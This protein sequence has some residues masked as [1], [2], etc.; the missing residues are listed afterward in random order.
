VTECINIALFDQYSLKLVKAEMGRTKLPMFDQYREEHLIL[1]QL[2]KQITTMVRSWNE[3]PLK[4]A[5]E[6]NERINEE[7]IGTILVST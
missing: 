3:L 1:D 5:L 6:I 7:D 4:Q 2:A